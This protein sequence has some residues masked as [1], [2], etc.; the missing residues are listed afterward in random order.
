MDPKGIGTSDIF[1]PP[2]LLAEITKVLWPA[3]QPE[4]D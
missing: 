4:T 3:K 1:S 2:P